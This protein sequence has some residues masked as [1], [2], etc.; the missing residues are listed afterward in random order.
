MTQS[1]A[2]ASGT[3]ACGTFAAATPTP[4]PAVTEEP[5][6][7]RTVHVSTAEELLAAIAPNTEIV[8][9]AGVYNVGPEAKAF[10]G[11]SPYCTFDTGDYSG[12][13]PF[14]LIS[15]VENLYIRAEEGADCVLA[16]AHKESCEA[17]LA[18]KD[19]HGLTISGVTISG[20]AENDLLLKY[21]Y[22]VR[23]EGCTLL[24]D[25]DKAYP[26]MPMGIG[27]DHC[28]NVTV[29][30]C[31]IENCAS[32]IF[33]MTSKSVTVSGCEISGC[34]DAA[35]ISSVE[36][37]VFTG[38][39]IHDCRNEDSISDDGEQG[40]A[41]CLISFDGISDYVL[42]VTIKDCEFYNNKSTFF[43]S[44][45]GI[46]FVQL[47]GLNIHDNSFERLFEFEAASEH[48]GRYEI[49]NCDVDRNKIGTFLFCGYDDARVVLSGTSI[50]DNAIETVF[51]GDVTVTGCAFS[52]PN[53]AHW[54]GVDE[55]YS[56]IRTFIH[57]VEGNGLG[58]AD[59]CA[60][61]LKRD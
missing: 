44:S 24:W 7:Q 39:S 2:T 29:S 59:L 19:C 41:S 46:D 21:C 30:D 10:V 1:P 15:G 9:S 12:W 38:C 26:G 8:L 25:E 58:E 14:L 51:Y 36:N 48:A 16:A 23:V 40:D 49:S 43:F 27:L 35:W 42:S 53:I 52:N 54:I 50:V 28:D 6:T 22:D 20:S 33:A 57:D 55:S 47:S 17:V 5:T 13:D 56:D 11:E 18:L 34:M 61:T 3:D 31:R 45:N 60:M 4:T 37:V 32:A